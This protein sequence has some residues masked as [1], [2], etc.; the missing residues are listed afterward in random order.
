MIQIKHHGD[1]TRTLAF[2]KTAPNKLHR[3][4]LEE[5]AKEAIK[6]L[7]AATPV[8]TG[9]TAKSWTYSIVRRSGEITITFKNTN[10]ND[11]V[12]IALILQYGHATGTGGW[13]AG[14]D[15][16]NP[17]LKPIFDKIEREAWRELN[18]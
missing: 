8:D 6:A 15:Y 10:I 12:P 1:F 3:M 16:I 13:V 7:E 5:Y 11:G 18:N 17:A 2:L 14:R 9:K 4:K